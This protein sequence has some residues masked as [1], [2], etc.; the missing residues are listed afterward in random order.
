MVLRVIVVQRPALV[1]FL[2]FLGRMVSADVEGPADCRAGQMVPGSIRCS[3]RSSVPLADLK[4][5]GVAK[6]GFYLQPIPRISSACR[7]GDTGQ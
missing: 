1:V 7:V 5:L 2:P 3:L 4:Q 6:E